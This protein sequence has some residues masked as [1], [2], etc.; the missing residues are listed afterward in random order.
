MKTGV[1]KMKELNFSEEE[2]WWAIDD[3][4]RNTKNSMTKEEIVKNPNIN[5]ILINGLYERVKDLCGTLEAEVE[6]LREE[7]ET[8]KK[9]MED[10]LK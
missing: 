3:Y 2:R 1:S 7:N 8:L 5:A 4:E 6:R 9:Q 10:D